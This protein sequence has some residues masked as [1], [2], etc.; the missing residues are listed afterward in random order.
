MNKKELKKLWT[1]V[2]KGEISEREAEELMEGK[3]TQPEGSVREIKGKS[4]RDEPSEA[5]HKGQNH[6]RKRKKPI[7]VREVKK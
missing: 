1:R 5:V 3:K 6:T 7:K 2:A 4:K